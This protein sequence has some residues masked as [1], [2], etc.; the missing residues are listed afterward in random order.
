MIETPNFLTTDKVLRR[1]LRRTALVLWHLQ[2]RLRHHS[3]DGAVCGAHVRHH[4]LLRPNLVQGQPRHDCA[5]QKLLK[6]PVRETALGWVE[7]TP[8]SQLYFDWW[9]FQFTSLERNQ[10]YT[11]TQSL[12]IRQ[13]MEMIK[14]ITEKVSFFKYVVYQVKVRFKMKHS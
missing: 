14:K 2:T 4:V 10:K 1:V 3:D 5:K 13:Y 11:V 12:I 6:Q 9:D 8:A 7:K